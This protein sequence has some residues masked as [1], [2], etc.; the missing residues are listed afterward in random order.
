MYLSHFFSGSTHRGEIDT[1]L[2][3]FLFVLADSDGFKTGK[4]LLRSL[5]SSCFLIIPPL[6]INTSLQTINES[7]CFLQA[8]AHM[9]SILTCAATAYRA[10][11]IFGV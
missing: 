7:P 3:S 5:S 9:S 1:M 6:R 10:L 11:G 4:F 2:S 8:V